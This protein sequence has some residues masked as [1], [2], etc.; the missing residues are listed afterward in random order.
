LLLE[1]VV[2]ALTATD[3]ALV[4]GPENFNVVLSGATSSTGAD[5]QLDANAATEQVEITDNDYAT[6]NL[7]QNS[8]PVDEGVAID[9]TI[10]LDG[11]TDSTTATTGPFVLQAGEDASTIVS[12]TNGTTDGADRD[13]YSDFS[14]ALSTAVTAFN[15][16]AGVNSGDDG[17]FIFNA[18]LLTFRGDSATE[19]SLTFTLTAED[20]DLVEGVE[21]FNVS[22]TTTTVQLVTNA[23]VSESFAQQNLTN[24][25]IQAGQAEA[26]AANAQG[27]ANSLADTVARDCTSPN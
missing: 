18:G 3:D 11:G 26:D 9:Y 14:A 16:A 20:D 2:V 21:N 10:S 13:D 17:S 7:S 27:A 8:S 12:L 25:Q 23:E 5:V 15:T 19:P 6:F 4:E 24:A 1:D 22:L